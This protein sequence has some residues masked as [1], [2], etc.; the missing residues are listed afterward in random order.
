[1]QKQGTVV[2]WDETKGFG[3]IRSP[4][5]PED[6]FFHVRD[7]E[8]LNPPTLQVAVAFEEINVGEKAPAPWAW[9]RQV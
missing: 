1:M 3:F 7:Y 2:A 4:Q 9:C 5:T 6:V 8:G